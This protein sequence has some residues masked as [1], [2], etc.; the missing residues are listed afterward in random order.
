MCRSGS[1]TSDKG[2]TRPDAGSVH[3]TVRPW[4]AEP[5]RVAVGE[6]S[7]GA[8]N[9][10]CQPPSRHWKERHF[11]TAEATRYRSYHP[12]A[13]YMFCTASTVTTAA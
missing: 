2:W 4:T 13:H 11:M 9:S 1:V 5:R 10:D 8:A 3:R 12:H 6:E 7:L